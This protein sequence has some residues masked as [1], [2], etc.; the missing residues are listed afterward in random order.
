M[1]A[2]ANGDVERV[3]DDAGSRRS[4]EVG[5]RRVV[6]QRRDRDLLTEFR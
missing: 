2:F 5:M 4:K 1:V 6:A 3:F